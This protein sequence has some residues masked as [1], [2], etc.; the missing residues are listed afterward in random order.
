MKKIQLTYEEIFNEIE[1]DD[2]DVTIKWPESDLICLPQF[3]DKKH[4]QVKTLTKP[5]KQISKIQNEKNAELERMFDVDLNIEQVNYLS[6]ENLKNLSKTE[7]L[8][9]RE[10]VS[11]E[12][13]WIQQAIQSRLQVTLQVTTHFLSSLLNNVFFIK[14]FAIKEKF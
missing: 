5:D 7:L 8:S 2:S 13:L 4:L 1:G 9:V 6:T 11:L 3:I 12:M 10:N 14:V